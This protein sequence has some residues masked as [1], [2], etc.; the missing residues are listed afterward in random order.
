MLGCEYRCFNRLL[1][2]W[3]ILKICHIC[4]CYETIIHQ[5]SAIFHHFPFISEYVFGP[6][7]LITNMY[8]TCD[9]EG[10]G[11]LMGP[12]GTMSIGRT[13]WCPRN[14]DWGFSHGLT[15]FN[16]LTD[17][18]LILFPFHKQPQRFW[19]CHFLEVHPV[20][21]EWVTVGSLG[22]PPVAYK[23]LEVISKPV[24]PWIQVAC[25]WGQFGEVEQL[26]EK[27]GLRQGIGET[28]NPNVSDVG[29][30]EMLKSR[31][32]NCR[33]SKVHEVHIVTEPSS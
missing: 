28:E 13:W 32:L 3:S 18:I 20:N 21:H 24:T 31:K 15:M 14:W 33:K 19:F 1:R 27:N 2:F 22:N 17:P 10:F 4:S 6:K 26:R 12:L 9:A 5:L 7:K 25:H 23:M 30:V 29:H 11:V 16:G 8:Q